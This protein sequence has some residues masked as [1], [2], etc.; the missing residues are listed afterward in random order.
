MLPPVTFER[1]EPPTFLREPVDDQIGAQSLV[2]DIAGRGNENTQTC[3]SFF[4]DRS[5]VLAHAFKPQL[6]GITIIDA[7]Q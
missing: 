5:L 6:R 2:G 7:S 4:S 1:K 3:R